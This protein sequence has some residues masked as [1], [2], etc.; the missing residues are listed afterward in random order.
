VI[1]FNTATQTVPPAEVGGHPRPLPR[2][3]GIDPRPSAERLLAYCRTQ[4]WAGYDPYD[5]LNSRLLKTIPFLD[6][7]IPRIA[8]TQLLKRSPFNVRPLLA[9]PKT[10]NPKALG[11]FLKA[12]LKLDRH[13]LIDDNQM[14]TGFVDRLIEL[15]SPNARHWCWGYSF[16]WQTRTIVVPTGTPNLVCTTFVT[17]ALLDMYDQRGDA[18]CLEMARSAASYIADDLYWF[19]DD[20]IASFDYPLPGL[21]SRIHN[22][23]FLAAALLSRVWTHTRES[24]LL[25]VALAVARYSARRQRSDGSWVYGEAVTQ[26][27]VDNFHT[28]YNLGGLRALAAYA[29]TDEFDE[30]IRRG[31][32]FYLAHFIREDGAPA[33]FHNQLYPIDVHCVAQSVITLAEFQDADSRCLAMAYSVFEWAMKHMWDERGFF[34]YR[35]L[36]LGTIRT[37]YMRWSQAWMLLAIATLLDS[38]TVQSTERVMPVPSHSTI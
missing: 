30:F 31:L 14:A 5:A 19:G 33:Y 17:D 2:R 21:R 37:S 26:Q 9:V 13:G 3:P 34:Y 12:A 23:N 24:R 6:F 1:T 25:D 7:R 32:E 28:G 11:L 27:W 38:A 4:G 22:A 29:E 18:R 16:P 36:R 8:L 15:R 10:Q 20:G 35:V